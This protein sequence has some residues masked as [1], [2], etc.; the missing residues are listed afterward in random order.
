MTDNGFA[1]GGSLVTEFEERVAADPDLCAVVC[2]EESLSFGELNVRASRLAG[3]LRGRG[4]G[5][6][7]VVAVALPRSVDLVVAVLG[8]L[9]AGAVYVPVDVDYPAERIAV[10]LDDACPAVVVTASSVVLPEGV[11]RVVL[12]AA[13]TAAEPARPARVRAGQLAYVIYTS[14]SS[15]R[16]KGVGVEHGSLVNL[17]GSHRRRLFG[18]ARERVGGRRLRVAHAAS[19]SFDGSWNPLLWMV[20]GHELHLI[21]E[22]T[23][24]DPDAL[25]ARL[26]EARVDVLHGTPAFVQRLVAAG[27]FAQ[28]RHRLTALC[29]AGEAIG[30]ALWQELRARPGCLSV[31]FYGPT[32][33]T[34]DATMALP[35]EHASEVIG[36]PLDNT[37][38][39][40]LDEN[41]R[42]VAE[43]VA[44]ELYLSGAGLARGYVGRAGL[45]AERFVADPFLPGRRM[46][47]TGDLAHWTARGGLEF[48]GR[49]DDQVKLRGFRVELGEIQTTLEAHPGVARSAV[50]LRED[51]PGN[52][53]IVGYVVRTADDAS[54]ERVQAAEA[55]HVDR[56]RAIYDARDD[57]TPAD[58]PWDDFSRWIS[59]F[60]GRPI[61]RQEMRHWQT[62][63]ADRILALR[64]RRV[65]EI[66]VGNGLIMSQVA[67]RCAEYWGTDV[68][69][70]L[71]TELREHVARDAEIGPRVR[72]LAQPAHV[73]DG[74]PGERFD[75]I[76]INSVIQ[77]FPSADY[78]VDV[79][80]KSLGLLADGG[81]IF[82]GD[83]RNLRL[84]RGFHTA[85]QRH[86][87]G[88]AAD[89]PALRAAVRRGV[90]LE[91]ELLLDPDFFPAL[92]AELE[93]IGGID[94]HV[95]RGR[96]DN[97]VTRYRYDVVLRKGE[98]PREAEPAAWVWGKEVAD[99]DALRTELVRRRP[100]RLRVARI[101]NARLARDRALLAALDGDLP[102]RDDTAAPHPEE[103][104]EL[105]AGT[106][107]RAEVTWS[108][109][110]D[111]GALDVVLTGPA[112]APGTDLYRP[113]G[114]VTGR[115]ETY[116]NN[117]ADSLDTELLGTELQAY[118]AGRLPAH[119]V[120]DAVMVVDR[121]PLTAN[122]KIDRAALPAP[123]SRQAATGRPPRSPRE[124]ILCDLFAETLGL[125]SVGADDD[126]F[127]L[128]GHSLMAMRLVDRVRSVLHADL[129]VRDVLE[130]P[131]VARL[132]E[133]ARDAG[134]AEARP[135]FQPVR[136]PS[137]VPLSFAQSRLWF[138][139]RAEGPSPTYNV[140]LVFRMV[141]DLDRDALRDALA[142]V[143]DRH[144]VL[145]T[146][147]AEHDGV[148]GQVVL[149]AAGA[150][151][152]LDVRAVGAEA[153]DDALAVAARR[154]FDLATEPPVR[155]TL[156]ATGPRE[157][158]LLL[159]LHHIAGDGWSRAPLA[160][161]LATAYAAR[162]AGRAP[163]WAP[164]RVQYADYAIC[165]Q[166]FLGDARDP[167]S[168]IAR[169][170]AY[171]RTALAGL[172][173]RIALP[174]DRP[175]SA[176]TTH[177]G[178]VFDFTLEPG[179]HEAVKRLA[180][181][182][183]AT[184]FMVLQAALA[185]LL[186]RLGAGTDIP[187]GSP[188]A[189]RTDEALDELV[190][191][192]V[193]T[194]VLRTDTSGDPTVRELLARVRTADLAAYAHSDVP[195]EQVVEAVNPERSLSGQPLFQVM[196]ALQNTPRQGAD[197]PGLEV[198]TEMIGAA[199]T[200]F[201]LTFSV[202]EPG[203]LGTADGLTGRAEYSSDLFDR[204]TVETIVERWAR[205]LRA[206]VEDPGRRIGAIEVLS[207][208]ERHTLLATGDQER[209]GPGACL[210]ELFEAQ[211]ARTPDAVAVRSPGAELSYADL[212]ARANRLAR[213]LIGRGVGPDDIVALVLPRSVEL[214]VAVL[215][216]L[217][218]GAAYL[219]VDPGQPA[220]R[221]RFLL[222]DAAPA[223][224]VD[225]P[226]VIRE[227][228]AYEDRRVS[229]ADRIRPLRPENTAYVIYT[230]GSGGRPKAVLVSH[231][232]LSDLAEAHAAGPGARVL[233]VAAPTFDV[234]VGDLCMALLSGATLV[235]PPDRPLYGDALAEALR[236]Y[237][238]THVQL[239]APVLA[240]LPRKPFPALEVVFVGGDVCPPDVAGYWSRDRVLRNVYGPT[241]ATVCAT[242]SAPLSGE[243]VPPMGRPLPGTRA[244]VLDAGLRPVPAGTVGELYLGGAGLARGY[245]GR[246]GP[247]AERFVADPFGAA[248]DRLYRTGDLVR[249]TAGGR[250]VFAGRADD[251]V[252]IRGV[253][254]EPG[255]I[256]AALVRHPAVTGAAVVA[257]GEGIEDRR[258]A[259]YVTRDGQDAPE[260]LVA[261]LRHH[262]TERLPAYLRPAFI[263][264]LDALPLTR[265]GK[266]DRAALPDPVVET[267]GPARAPR[268]P[269]EHTLCR[270]FADLLGV[271][272]IGRDDDFF[273]LGGHS[274][275]ATRLVSRL[276]TELGDEVPIRAVFERPTAAGLAEICTGGRSTRPALRR[277]ERPA[278]LPLSFGQRRL[279]F[280]HRLDGAGATDNS[281][282]ALRLTGPLDRGALRRALADLVARH[283]TL[284]TVFLDDEGVPRQ[285]L[286]DI[287]VAAPGLDV[288][289]CSRDGLDEALRTGARHHFDLAAAPPLRAR[290]FALGPEEHV[291]LLVVHHIAADGYS[292]PSLVG[293]LALAYAARRDGAAPDWPPLPLT[294]AD[295]TLW[296][297]TLL[298]TET[299]PGS[300]IARQLAFWRD[301]L[302][303][304]P[305]ELA[306]PADRSRPSVAGHRGGA[307][308]LRVDAGL[309]ERLAA[310]GLDARATVFMVVQAG[311]AALLT[312]LGAGDDIPIGYP[313]A[314][315]TDEALDDLVGFF[316]NTLVLRADTSGDPS[317][318]ELLHRVRDAD[319][320]AYS[321]QDVP[322][323]YL[324][325]SLYPA[326]SLARHPLFQVMVSMR[327]AEGRAFDLGELAV[328]VEEV[329]VGAERFDLSVITEERVSTDGR[330]LGIDGV[331]AFREDLF[332]R[333]TV[334]RIAVR[335]VRLFEEVTTEPDRPIS[336]AELLDDAEYAWLAGM[337]DTARP[338]PGAGVLELFDRQVAATP[339]RRAVA[340][341][342]EELTYAE[343]DVRAGRL[344]GLLTARGAGP[345][346]VVALA[347]PRSA[348]LVVAVL[349]VLK[350]G[351]A[352]LPLDPAHPAER[353]AHMLDEAVPVCVLIA[354][355]ASLPDAAA[356]PRL[357]FDGAEVSAALSDGATAGPPGTRPGSP[358][359]VMYT[360]GSTGRPKGIAVPHQALANYVA[361]AADAYPGAGGTAL[362]HSPVSFD[363]TVTTLFVPLVTG[364]TVLVADLEGAPHA[365]DFAKVT[366]SHFALLDTLPPESSPIAEIVVGG[367][368]LTGETIHAWRSRRPAVTVTNEYGPTETT[369][370]CVRHRIVPGEA[371]GS[372]AVP[373]GRP[374]W[375]TRVQV[376]DAALRPVPP[377][378]AG[379]LY[380][381]GAGLARGY[382]R[383]PVRTAERFVADPYGP[384]G[385]RMY[386]T[387]DL[388]RWRADGVLEFLG[389]ADDQ[390]KIR[391]HRVEPGE[392]EAVLLR[393]PGVAG[394]AVAATP[395]R[396]G[397][398]RLVAY[399]VAASGA[400]PEP[401]EVSRHAARTLPAYMVPA[402]V[403][404]L[405]RIPLTANGKL[406]RA[407]LPAP[408]T[409]NVPSGS[410]PGT[411]VERTLCGVFAEILDVGEVGV[412]DGFFDL[413]GH[414]LLATRLVSR[415]RTTLG[416]E[417]ALRT[418]F[419]APTVAALARELDGAEHARPAVR[420]A[421][422]PDVL[423]LSF[424]QRRLW[425]LHRLDGPSPT[426]N[427]PLV[428]RLD[429]ELNRE[430]L[431]AA[432][433]D[434]VARHEVLRTVYPEVDGEPRQVILDAYRPRLRVRPVE[435]VEAGT[436]EAVRHCF[437]LATE[438]PLHAELLAQ[439][440]DRH[441]L[442]IVLHHIA[443]DGW[444]MEPLMRDLGLAYAARCGGD[445]PD[446]SPL[447]VQYADYALWQH[448]FLG[449]AADSDSVFA[450]QLGRWKER[451]AGLP[452]E[453]A[454]PADRPRPATASH[455]GDVVRFEL[456]A[457]L[458]LRL[459]EL[460]RTSRSSLFMV[461]QTGL[462][463][464]LTRLGAGTDIPLGSP[465]AGRTDDALNDLAGFFVNTLVLRT[466][467]AGDPTFRAL[468]ERVRETD[469]AAHA[470]QDVPFEYL[471]DALRPTRSMARHPLF[472]V[473]LALQN[474]A[475]Y[476]LRLPGVEVSSRLVNTGN[477]RFDLFVNLDERHAPD[478]SPAGLRGAVEYATDLFDRS[479]VQRLVAYLRRLLTA[480]A[481][482]PGL[483]IGRLPLMSAAERH[484]VVVGHNDTARDL[485]AASLPELF[486]AQ[487]ART[488]EAVALV[489][490]GE[491]LT[492]AELNGRADRLA[493]ALAERG[494]GRESIV[495]IALPRSPD[496]V[497]AVLAV[498]KSGGAYLPLDANLPAGRLTAMLDDARPALLLTRSDAH[499]V[500]VTT[501]R[502]QVDEPEA[503]SS[504]TPPVRRPEPG[505]AA[506]VLYT[507]GSTGRPKGV[508]VTHGALA[509]LL[510]AMG[511]E[512]GLDAGDRLIAVTNVGFDI[513]AL[514]LYLPLLAGA[515]VVLAT[516]DA[517]G[518]PAAL[519]ALITERR[520]TVMQ[521]TPSLWQV[522]LAHDAGSVRGLRA[523]V[524]GEAL[525][526]RL[527]ARMREVCGPVT[528]V[529]GP[530]ETTIW[531]T[532]ERLVE[533]S[534]GD[535]PIG[536]PIGN[537]RVYVLDDDMRPMPPG[538]VGELYIAG[539]GL[540]RGYLGRPDLTAERFVAD[541]FG[542][543]G[544]RAYRTGDLA[545]WTTGG[546]LRFRG[547][548]DAQI[549][550]RGFRIELGEIE[551][552]LT[553]N[554][555][556]AE[557]VAT[558]DEDRGGE[559]R[560]AAYVVPAKASEAARADAERTHIGGWRQI[561]GEAY[562]GMPDGVLGEDFSLW[563]S[564]YTGTPIPL[565]EMNEWRAAIVARIAELRP[566][567]LLEVGVG[568]GALLAKLAPG[569]AAY[570]GIDISPAA[571]DRL[572]GQ[573]ERL[574][575]LASR[576]TLD[577][578]PADD[579]TGLP[580]GF[581]DTIV[582]NSVA[583]YL[584]AADHLI[585]VL[586]TALG[587]L[588]PGGALFIGDVRNLRTARCLHTAIQVR[589]ALDD[590]G[591]AVR[592]LARRSLLTEK[593]LLVDPEFFTALPS[594]LP[595]I[596][597]VDV[598]VKR[599]G[600]D[601]EL[602]RHRYDVTLHRSPVRPVDLAG[603]TTVRWG[604]DLSTLDELAERL[605]QDRDAVRLA[606]LPNARLAGEVAAAEALDEHRP[607][608]E[609]L[610][611]LDDRRGPDLEEL[612]A[613]G[614]RLGYRAV[615]TWAGNVGDGGL[616]VGFLPPAARV[617]T[618]VY[619]P[620]GHRPPAAYTNDPVAFHDAHELE[621]SILRD[622]RR[623]LPDYM[624]PS[625]VVV[626]GEL[627]L[628]P[629]GKL[630][631]TAL[632]DPGVGSR[633]AGRTARSPREQ[634][635]CDLFAEILGVS[636]VGVDD[637]FFQ[638]GGHS[639]LAT[640]LVSRVRTTTG[641]E[642]P[643]RAVFEAPTV[644]GLAER[645]EDGGAG[646][647]ALRPLERPRVVPLS[648]AQRRLWFLHRL[649]G[650]GA[651]YN[652]PITVRLTGRLDVG[653]LRAALGDVVARHESLRTVFP[654]DGGTPRQHILEPGE[655]EPALP[656]TACGEAEI[657]HALRA[658]VSR[659]FDLEAEPPLRAELFA[660]GPDE[661]ILLVLLH[662]IAGD[663]WSLSCLSRDLTGAYAARCENRAPGWRPLPVQ[664]ADY[665]LWQRDLLGSERDE[666]SP[667]A[668]QLAY[669]KTA[670]KD[671]PE[672]IALPADRPRPATVSYRGAAV[673]FR[674]DA[675]LH[676][677]LVALAAE[678]GATVFMVLQA[679]LATLLSRLGAGDDIPLGSPIAGRTDEALGEL[680]GFFVN[681][682]VLR[683]DTSGDP[684]FRELLSR[685]RTTDLAAYDNQDV[686]FEYLVEAVNP[687]RS[688]SRHP[689]FQV[690]L[691]LQNTPAADFGL[692]GLA[693]EPE[694]VHTRTS[695]FDL[696]VGLH[697]RHGADGAP[698]GMDGLAEY[699][700]DLFEEKTVSTLLD[701]LARVLHAVVTDQDLPIRR[702]DLLTVEERRALTN[703]WIDTA[704]A[705]PEV[706]V[707]ELLRAQAA[708]TPETMALICEP[709]SGEEPVEL[710]Y[711]ELNARANRLA[712][713][714][715]DRGVGPEEFVALVLPRRPEMIVA[716]L[717]V[718][719]T[720]AAYL[721]IDTDY[722][723]AR[724]AMMLDDARP[725]CALVMESTR[726]LVDEDATA[727]VVLDAPD[728]VAA[729]DRLPCGDVP[730]AERVRPGHPLNPA[731]LV[732]TSGST[733][734][735]KGVVMPVRGLVTLLTWHRRRF[736]AEVGTRTGQFTAIGFDFSV[737]EILAPLTSGRTLVLPSDAIRRDFHRLV[738]WIDRRRVNELFAP[739]LAISVL[740]QAARSKGSDL[741]SLTDVL[742]GGEAFT[743]GPQIRALYDD[744]RGRRAHNIYGPAETHCATTWT[745]PEDVG[746]WPAAAP[747]GRPLGN[748]RVYVL[749]RGLQP[750]PPG[751]VGEVYVAT[752]KLA[753]GYW[754]RP[755]VT[756][757]R[758][759]ADPIGA[760]G[761][762][763]Y[764]TGDLA[765]WRADGVLEFIGR[766]DDQ[767]KIRGFRV[768]LGEVEGALRDVDGVNDAV[769]TVRRDAQ[770]YE[771]LVAYVVTGHVDVAPAGLRAHL[772]DVLPEHMIPAQIAVL[773]GLPFS[774]NGKVDRA[775]LP[776]P[777]TSGAGGRAPSA[778]LER[779]VAALWADLLAR[780]DIGADDG[781]FELGGHSLLAMRLIAAIQEVLGVRIPVR[782]VFE[783]PTVAQQ[784][785]RVEE[786][787]RDRGI[788]VA[789]P[790]QVALEVLSL[791]D[792]DVAAMLAEH[793]T[794]SRDDTPVRPTDTDTR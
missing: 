703:D 579:L 81:S 56:W 264:V 183:Q 172:P 501:A 601:N 206:M 218:A 139:H 526:A 659:G 629:N 107:Y 576:V 720:G 479:T 48:L 436:A 748:A 32:E 316:V 86:R 182:N 404:V 85:L 135:R 136:R 652:L 29:L 639:L 458:H 367:E 88:G 327:G 143:V 200:R 263:V 232:G 454:L 262:L 25:V 764:R 563:R 30:D 307:V 52:P 42:P 758:F 696:F 781:F 177:R 739:T 559:R 602:T 39:Y 100:A 578:R 300:P 542:P 558:V 31:N 154:V 357:R 660:V 208:E 502:L 447:P 603:V 240:T 392:V 359:Y 510:H 361:W 337:N 150:A 506:Y 769:A 342:E 77:Y 294:Y 531:S 482:D 331:I 217:K 743:L 125:A 10:L 536:R 289:E 23:R 197:L 250:L 131:T 575:E 266:L 633:P 448:E 157:H 785:A 430:A 323:E 127:E 288:T 732:Y 58:V 534:T 11:A 98:A 771:R 540:A 460:A 221:I 354:G 754:R 608:S 585:G 450:R 156:F 352:Y 301:T 219:P 37:A 226:A 596:G 790:A 646:R 496:L 336:T 35:S 364:G 360:S 4:V 421:A 73:T 168:P 328:G 434:L 284:R 466:D 425:F 706:S 26:T 500:P 478:G 736:P 717:A 773:P 788:D 480:A 119:M 474:A 774:P 657:G 641:A 347:L 152:G 427:I 749:D 255:E 46:Y 553:A 449:E 176:A 704:E 622:L 339:D 18:P 113:A 477:A 201:D 789:G 406:D 356:V 241:E 476:R 207:A 452:E 710:S 346:K 341:G 169:Q 566:R 393:H 794:S 527:A 687:S 186:T 590:D 490:A 114:P 268:S 428:L 19:V 680:V 324:V 624:M 167:E 377:G 160:R 40:V 675:L 635:L 725:A 722:P 382:L 343:L 159:V 517:A 549:K 130:A 529:Y 89:L 94:V 8:V 16:P 684:T 252:K 6:E 5:A 611:R 92:R 338:V 681:T 414:S 665:A 672:E 503:M 679:A 402:H 719:K 565:P 591:A 583:Q 671:L 627:P 694:P 196:L 349:A 362:L 38:A 676:S 329:R 568:S 731:Y 132:A 214:A 441:T 179:L 21:D 408:E 653:A 379:E 513:S 210:P 400:G 224:T 556:V 518:D 505:Q 464:L 12:D 246:P 313:V 699:S 483:P 394:A 225:D 791:T 475:A 166:E 612:C 374:V 243:T 227:S 67:P 2:G 199:A 760:A 267:A 353:V 619:R 148:P 174:A 137:T 209:R 467:T 298:G 63:T 164:L 418:V 412:D 55:R 319:V 692:P 122:G 204:R 711:V 424:A 586:R 283:E 658:A 274:L 83:I 74:L 124:E 161:D 286:L 365:H 686:P 471:V 282:L 87:L 508:V 426:Y 507:S 184:V 595:E 411:P 753:R 519:A 740:A 306:L 145:R 416:V 763:M 192:F 410:G 792:D 409:A 277:A 129:T 80:R 105:G 390:V 709:T 220:E 647:P 121:M 750:L 735:P 110:R 473:M 215:G 259:A 662:H 747:I 432:F 413:G 248:G 442:A 674:L 351:A 645:L 322:F 236:A 314:G 439:A 581:F 714:L 433:G 682:L 777:V 318:R 673:T 103:F 422:R 669:W 198:T 49:G 571:I 330:P 386:R 685:V 600:H 459:T 431:E 498:L 44:G 593:E 648:Y 358:A 492:Y 435:D 134:H 786:V 729:L 295:Y 640:R 116:A 643:V 123:F 642:L 9:K 383:R 97:E 380:V 69:A 655:A 238:V 606:D 594:V 20:D 623:H 456:D 607:A 584:P 738:E 385:T 348:G 155:A 614:E 465:V 325:E 242:M 705:V 537:T 746:E 561:Y 552:A 106:G 488:P 651:T 535:P 133:V 469:L 229:D 495:A 618:G 713:L 636:R 93:G 718:L 599:A 334:E 187:L 1:A 663:G 545:C 144:E 628:T 170:I 689:L 762:R 373:I 509:N 212:D 345:E 691:A 90:L 371:V 649:E 287:G 95:K 767:V 609:A 637:D 650:P 372:G 305:E 405:D 666:D 445:A 573:V 668:R 228:A 64:P 708:A 297:R 292:I 497:V 47:R 683:T 451:L 332:D 34:V 610:A 784:A 745:L 532:A 765:K 547:R 230:S 239:T 661:H 420:A 117:P 702:I 101:P 70:A 189:G 630:D 677:G 574:P 712:R 279:W 588:T 303:G 678:S 463:A 437:D 567:R 780:T 296:Q 304:L 335:L 355:D 53:R 776:E 237:A 667:L 71:I 399:V 309:H 634:I 147:F 3:L 7:S 33:F 45:T 721:P 557:A 701:R 690:M 470:D 419:E 446:W 102:E 546:R 485:P 115:P 175:A 79:L 158:V 333:E 54:P 489:C 312:R 654:S 775:A 78:L 299:D 724:V 72:L 632:P 716:H 598:R 544:S 387:G 260:T 415:I 468:L 223:L 693:A 587:L 381:A 572:R 368:Q 275:L 370:G 120:P 269:V 741:A 50:V 203:A 730:E 43:G 68:S 27:L 443:G 193:N 737:Q 440:P 141:G 128:G 543:P 15:G 734:R 211:V 291:L 695:R 515:T 757:E 91:K 766:V 486:A 254:V 793:E 707:S 326:R 181:Q 617:L 548:V 276:R 615:P 195:F 787:G 504:I 231:A 202:S 759:V 429:G 580:T 173:G 265:N 494:V 273:A 180:R 311:L 222:S 778:P 755:G 530:T 59:S 60:D 257:R 366:P 538:A 768:E 616:E 285:V 61:P 733:G 112:A 398:L 272:E 308:P 162:R 17:L 742:Q 491:D 541:P 109:D 315:R 560:L 278:T 244:Y 511:E 403:V 638:L 772:Q 369:V 698:L 235:L 562:E 108:G 57:A 205:T 99:L 396:S 138:L 234:A 613:L 472:Q 397:A 514:E 194:L 761:S 569:C 631:R 550:L 484:A 261:D 582:I 644:A 604:R 522:L 521:A 389:R 438:P 363:L 253:R 423:R 723:G 499:G 126:F 455:R 270:I 770:G 111:G 62:T 163:G 28:D 118:V 213:L 142:D 528:N 340:D 700:T 453:L 626:L 302:A 384:P 461:L 178:D 256:E 41:L 533:W 165:H 589:Q 188:I 597:A 24:R 190:G 457:P 697:E 555:A 417:V 151:P 670:L 310:L 592:A 625:G 146:V 76:V 216:V 570:W 245:L 350:A 271:A 280:L 378:I 577:V 247:T 249:W 281:P 251:Q 481:D 524:G 512:A 525:P 22:P 321:N 620:A 751:A 104:H 36:G 14:G 185:T 520:G 395:D 290:L 605:A 756:A 51:V 462:A 523:L 376:L 493:G 516:D 320:A 779:V 782:T 664:Y 726:R 539:A 554:P 65:L 752:A 783:S 191:F 233:Q 487:A 140:P 375:N 564:C 82:V 401:D 391:G 84:L 727:T 728:V 96:H 444:S 149:P 715:I 688:L 153:V 66:G 656:V 171:W 407:A 388:A 13:D 75:T 551:S 744:G 258:L 621:A 344:A 317:F 293:D